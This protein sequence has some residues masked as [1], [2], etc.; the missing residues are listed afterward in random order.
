VPPDFDVFYRTE[1]GAV[2]GLAIAMTGDRAAA[3]ELV[4]DAFEAALRKWPLVGQM[5]KPGAWVRRVVSN[6]SVSAYRR[7]RT[8]TKYLTGAN[9]EEAIT[10]FPEEAVEVVVTIRQLPRRQA[11]ALWLRYFDDL[12]VSEVASIMGCGQETVKTHLTRGLARLK[13]ALG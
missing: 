9:T 4:Q 1:Y 2:L 8:R 12:P 10:G 5:D 6:R 3:E 13:E 7:L 11:Q